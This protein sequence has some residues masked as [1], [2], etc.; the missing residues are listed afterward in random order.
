MKHNFLNNSSQSLV[1]LPKSL[2]TPHLAHA[3]WS[4]YNTNESDWKAGKE[5]NRAAKIISPKDQSV[6]QHCFHH[7]NQLKTMQHGDI[8]ETWEL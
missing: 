6:R 5:H 1:V 8:T 3:L 4:I 2:V 7:Q